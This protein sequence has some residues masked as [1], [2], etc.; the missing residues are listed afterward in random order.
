VLL[1]HICDVVIRSIIVIERYL[2]SN[3]RGAL[4]FSLLSQ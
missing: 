2:I 3:P 1:T 4:L